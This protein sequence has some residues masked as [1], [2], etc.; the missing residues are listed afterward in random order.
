MLSPKSKGLR[1]SRSHLTVERL[2]TGERGGRPFFMRVLFLHVRWVHRSKD[3]VSIVS[4]PLIVAKG[5]AA[6]YREKPFRDVPH[7]SQPA[8][9]RRR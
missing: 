5:T 2:E 3:P 7:V 1:W 6:C 9:K 8:R 4:C